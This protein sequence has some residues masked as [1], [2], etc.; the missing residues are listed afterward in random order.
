MIQVVG[1]R[2][3]VH[4]GLDSFSGLG[5]QRPFVSIAMTVFLLSLAG[6][7][8]TGGFIGKVFILRAAIERGLLALA[9]VLVMTSLLS[10][11]YYLRVAWYMWFRE[12]A[13]GSTFE[14]IS[15]PGM[16][17]VAIA[18]AIAG[19]LLLGIF[20]GPVLD[21]AEQAAAALMAAPAETALGAR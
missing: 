12:P 19:T 13:E 10:Y 4:V 20:P 16:V 8:L 5:W 9:V 7:P 18:I 21:L 3:E 2:G 14:G 11:W 6:F 1:R 17:R 15:T